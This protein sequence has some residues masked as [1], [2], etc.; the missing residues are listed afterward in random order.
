MR[1]RSTACSRRGG[2][3]A[4]AAPGHA[5]LASHL[6][7]RVLRRRPPAALVCCAAQPGQGWQLAAAHRCGLC[8]HGRMRSSARV[9]SCGPGRSPPGAE[10]S[11]AERI[12]WLHRAAS[13]FCPAA[14]R[15][16]RRARRGP[17]RRLKPMCVLGGAQRR[18]TGPAWKRRWPRRISHAA[19]GTAPAPAPPQLAPLRCRQHS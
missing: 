3:R 1:H 2:R 8:C 6:A 7:E 19:P 11:A 4:A 12:G 17:R 13:V 15:L 5:H 9:R 10:G 14:P 16:R 18:T